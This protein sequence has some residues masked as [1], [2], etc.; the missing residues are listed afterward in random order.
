MPRTAGLHLSGVH[1]HAFGECSRGPTHTTIR[2]VSMKLAKLSQLSDKVDHIFDSQLQHPGYRQNKDE[3]E[4]TSSLHNK[5]VILMRIEL[6]SHRA[7]P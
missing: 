3:A 1:Q 6:H 7:K 4:A 2:M 5:K